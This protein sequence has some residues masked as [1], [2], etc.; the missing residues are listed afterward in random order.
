M[1][2]FWSWVLACALLAAHT[3]GA[4][5]GVAHARAGGPAA[6]ASKSIAAAPLAGLFNTHDDGSGCRLFDQLSHGDV[7]PTAVAAL[8]PVPLATCAG[9]PVASVATA[10]APHVRARGPPLLA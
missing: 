8:A 10:S 2:R 3:L 5:H 9:A 7:V 1:R 4:V 6:T